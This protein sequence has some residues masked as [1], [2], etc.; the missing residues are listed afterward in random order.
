VFSAIDLHM[1][2]AAPARGCTSFSVSM[3]IANW[4][5]AKTID[6]LIDRGR[7]R[8]RFSQRQ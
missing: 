7:R 8:K 1:S 3:S 6:L 5:R 4:I 2:R